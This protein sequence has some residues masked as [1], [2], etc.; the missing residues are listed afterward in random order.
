[1]RLEI[2]SFHYVEHISNKVKKDM[3]NYFQTI[4]QASFGVMLDFNKTSNYVPQSI[5]KL[6]D[7]LIPPRDQDLK[8]MR[9]HVHCQ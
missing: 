7:V 6:N 8:H 5:H 9:R 1:M 4:A 3:V 2:F